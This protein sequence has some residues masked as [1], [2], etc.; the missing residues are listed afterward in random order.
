MMVLRVGRERRIQEAG[1]KSAGLESEC[2]VNPTLRR[3]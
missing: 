2:G 1:S 3:D